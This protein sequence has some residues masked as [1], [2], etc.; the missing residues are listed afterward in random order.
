[1]WKDGYKERIKCANYDS[2]GHYSPEAQT[3]HIVETNESKQIKKKIFLIKTNSFL[4]EFKRITLQRIRK[5]IIILK[6]IYNQSS[7]D[8][9][10][11]LFDTPHDVQ[12]HNKRGWCPE[13]NDK[14]P[15]KKRKLYEDSDNDLDDDIEENTA[16]QQLWKMAKALNKNVSIKW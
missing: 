1:M 6:T 11:L 13:S 15:A 5:T 3:E 16:F 8:S 14:P 12:R 10:G 9:C 4:L 7:C 2:V